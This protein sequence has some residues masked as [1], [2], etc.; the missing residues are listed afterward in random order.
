MLYGGTSLVLVPL[1]L[2]Y[3]KDTQFMMIR[4][5]DLNLNECKSFKP[6]SYERGYFYSPKS[7]VYKN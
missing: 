1:F 6:R 3:N 2:C 7:N 4:I 5:S